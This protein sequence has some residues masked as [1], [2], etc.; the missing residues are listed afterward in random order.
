VVITTYDTVVN[1]ISIVRAVNWSWLVCDEAQALKNPDAGRRAALCE[2]SSQRTVLMTGTPVETS[3]LDL[4]SLA[5]VAVPGILGER[6]AFQLQ[7]P[8]SASAARAISVFTD[9]IVLRR[10]VADVAADL[11][12]RID[13]DEPIDLGDEL[14]VEYEAVRQEAL[15]SYAVAGALVAS[16]RLQLFCAHPSLVNKDD[17]RPLQG[18]NLLDRSELGAELMTPKVE[19]TIELVREAFGNRRKVLIF[20]I[21]NYC[22]EIILRA[23]HDLPPAFWGVINGSTESSLR[24][25]IVDQFS[26]YDGPACLVLNPRS[27]GAGLNITAATVVIHFTQAWNPALEAQAS[28]RAHRRGQSSVVNIYRLFYEDTVE[29]VMIDRAARRRRLGES[30]ITDSEVD[31]SDLSRALS[32][33][34]E[35]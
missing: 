21:F 1:D 18:A 3:L 5:D 31:A 14:A 12:E 15:R 6:A 13:K 23:A 11:P 16:T 29:R 2:V 35:H 32:I 27:A 28:A 4:W 26:D 22:A 19:R 10:R 24:Q 20:A 34:P 33:R 7:F 9:P 30:A 17:T 25:N 8:D